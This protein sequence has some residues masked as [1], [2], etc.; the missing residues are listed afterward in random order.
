MARG[1]TTTTISSC[2][3]ATGWRARASSTSGRATTASAAGISAAG[4]RRSFPRDLLAHEYNHSWNGKYRRPADLFTANFNTPMRN[5]LLWVYE[6]QTQYYG[7]VVAARAGFVTKDQALDLLANTA[8]IYDKRTGRDWRPLADT[9]LDPVIA[10]RRSPPWGNWQRKR[11]LLFRR[12]AD[13]AR[14]RHAHPGEVG[15]QAFARRFRQG[16]FRRERWRLGHAD[17]YARRNWWRRSTRS[18]PMTGRNS[19]RSGSTRL[20]RS[21]A[22][23]AWSVAGWKLVYGDTP[24]TVWRDGEVRSRGANLLYLH[25]A[26]GR[27]DRQDHPDPVGQPGVQG[28][29]DDGLDDHRRQRRGVSLPTS[30]G[31]AVAGSKSKPVE[32]LIRFGEAFKTIKLDYN[33]GHKYPRL[34]RVSGKPDLI[35]PI[36]TAS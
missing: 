30:C 27:P 6:G 7:N 15:R 22:G 19:S 36:Y 11:G 26:A 16:V 9:T 25:R 28:G 13:L 29:A 33:G 17:L 5:S 23:G 1:I 18:S 32:L 35:T 20:R 24:N 34:E 3:S 4:T 10:A 12:P 21:A 2:R 14:C 31:W 8:A